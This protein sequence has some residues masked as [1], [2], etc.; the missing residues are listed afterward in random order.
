V[1]LF[2]RFFFR[3][4]EKKYGYLKSNAID[5]PE[6]SGHLFCEELEINPK[7]LQFSGVITSFGEDAM[8]NW[9]VFLK[10]LA[11]FLL[12]KKVMHLRLQFL[13]SFLNIKNKGLNCL[14]NVKYMEER[15]Q[16]FRFSKRRIIETPLQIQD[17]WETLRSLIF[18]HKHYV[19]E[20]EDDKQ[21]VEM[22]AEE[23]LAVSCLL[24]EDIAP[25]FDYLYDIV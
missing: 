23:C 24:P 7:V 4:I 8:V 6:I 5:K 22:R 19:F 21:K 25:L 17:I 2:K 11:I 15:L 1:R 12:R 10:I 14:Q 18:E 9:I 13:V 20:N 3:T 16:A